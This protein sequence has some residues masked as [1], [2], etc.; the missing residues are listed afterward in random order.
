MTVEPHAP[1]RLIRSL[2]IEVDRF[3]VGRPGREHCRRMMGELA[4]VAAVDVGRPDFGCA[5]GII[6]KRD[7]L[8]IRSDRWKPS[9]QRV[10][11]LMR[12][13]ALRIDDAEAR[14][15]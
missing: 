14:R 11:E 4:H 5:H 2:S 6:H 1:D 3:A 7:V 13:S 10:L 8:A 9:T 12:G 15:L